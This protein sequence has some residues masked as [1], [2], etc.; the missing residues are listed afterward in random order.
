MLKIAYRVCICCRFKLEYRRAQH[1]RSA[2]STSSGLKRKCFIFLLLQRNTVVTRREITDRLHLADIF[3][4]FRL[5]QN[6]NSIRE[7]MERTDRAIRQKETK[8]IR[9]MKEEDLFRI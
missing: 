1:R 8:V 7:E 9:Q 2:D 3:V 6:V 5:R 4:D